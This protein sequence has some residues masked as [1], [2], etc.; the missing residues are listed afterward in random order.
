[1]IDHLSRPLAS[2][3]LTL[4]IA[5]G[6]VLTPR[7]QE[8]PVATQQ[9]EGVIRRGVFITVLRRGQEPTINISKVS[10]NGIVVGSAPPQG[11]VLRWLPR[12]RAPEN[13][14]GA[15]AFS[16]LNRLPLISQ[17]G[18]TI[19][20]NHIEPDGG[21]TTIGVPRTWTDDTGWQP[22][23]GL[24]LRSSYLSGMSRDGTH[25]VGYGWDD[26]T[27]ALARP[28]MWSA[29]LG[30]QILPLI[31]PTYGG[32]AWA[33]SNDGSVVAGFQFDFPNL[34]D[35]R[36]RYY[37]TRWSE[38]NMRA[39]T[40]ATGVQL[41]Q[42]FSC[43]SDCSVVVGGGQ[44]G[45]PNPG[46]PNFGQAWYWAE[47]TGGVYLE[48]P[49]DAAPMTTS[50]STDVNGDGSMIIGTYYRAN[51]DGTVSYRGFLWTAESG[52]VPILDLLAQHGINYGSDWRSI[53]P[54]AITPGG[55][56]I[57]IGGQAANLTPGG[58]IIHL[59]QRAPRR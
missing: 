46:H 33:V 35:L 50:Y 19:A 27:S 11:N 40:D 41:G 7:A 37:A 39:L 57:L 54:T 29:E 12:R 55:D 28:W 30:Q 26:E 14:G 22:L 9:S 59:P 53:V 56:M 16:R 44:G 45:D 25:I 34:P 58:F 18:V 47:A 20:A 6:V 32:E 4:A 36:R 23:R 38:G 31:L 2:V 48:N 8:G 15:P 43:S 42:A 51:G 5:L 1:M 17:D 21:G 49:Q 3:F 10:A 13:L 24:T 52:V